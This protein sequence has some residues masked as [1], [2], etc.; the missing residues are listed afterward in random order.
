MPVPLYLVLPLALAALIWGYVFISKCGVIGGCVATILVGSVLGYPF[1]HVSV[2][3]LD[4]LMIGGMA[5]WFAHD[6][7]VGRISPKRLSRSDIALGAFIFALIFSTFTHD[8]KIQGAQPIATLLFF[9]LMPV[10]AYV[11]ASRCKVSDASHR[12]M[13]WTFALFGVYLSLTAVF[14]VLGVGALVFP[15]YISSPKHA[16]FLG[17]GRGPFLNP[18]GNGMYMIAAFI[19]SM[20]LWQYVVKIHRP[21]V[22]LL[23]GINLA[24]VLLTLTRSVWLG[25]G[26]AL[27]GMIVMLVPKQHRFRVVFAAGLMGVIALGLSGSSLSKFKRDKNVSADVMAESAKLRPILAAFA[28]EIFCDYPLSGVGFGQYKERNID[29]LTRRSFD[30]PMEKA[31]T[32]VQHNI[33]LSLLA[34]TGLVGLILFIVL[35]TQWL[36]D[37]WIVWHKRDKPIWE[38]QQGL[39]SMLLLFGY[40]P[41]GMFHELSLIPMLNMLVFFFAGLARGRRTAQQYSRRTSDA[42]AQW[43]MQRQQCERQ[44]AI[45]ASSS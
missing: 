19:A 44:R 5:V 15:R 24:G 9:Y 6:R 18:V 38:R 16:E 41:N 42:R 40:L 7:L 20:M 22:V 23:C 32:Y 39:F 27:L 11:I 4:R 29:Y 34:E 33:F 12:W 28:Y 37:G 2:I 13:M 3:T 1:F 8:F 17:R 14:E 21:L 31:K 25:A 43:Q 35:L 30:L 45:A 26:A 10:L 36:S